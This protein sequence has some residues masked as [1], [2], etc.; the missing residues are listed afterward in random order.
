MLPIIKLN[1]DD[2][3]L[4]ADNSRVHT[5]KIVK[6]ILETNSIKSLIWPPYSADLNIVEDIWSKLSETV[7]DN[8]QFNNP[9]D[10]KNEIERAILN[11]N[12]F[13][14]NF[15]KKLFSSMSTRLIKIIRKSGDILNK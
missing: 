11:I 8:A 6:Q 7:Y 14:R 4:Q 10:L 1:M 2:F 5:S 13:E 3:V 12:K 15:T 9:N